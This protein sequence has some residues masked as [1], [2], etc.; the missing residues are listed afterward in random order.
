MKD[1]VQGEERWRCLD[2]LLSVLRT[3]PT[4]IGLRCIIHGLVYANS[5]PACKPLSS[6][7]FKEENKGI[8]NDGSK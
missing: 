2:D 8:R 3:R 5:Q 4:W 1:E 7:S 6:Q